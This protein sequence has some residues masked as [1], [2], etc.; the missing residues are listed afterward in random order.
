MKRTLWFF[1]AVSM[2]M[3]V[4]AR[5]APQIQLDF[6]KLA[7][8]AVEKVEVALPK[9][10]LSLAAQFISED[11]KDAAK[12]KKLAGNLNGIY[13]RS[14]EFEKEGEFSLQDLEP[15]RRTITGS[16]WNCLVSVRNKKTS[17]NTDVCLRQDGEKIL[18]LAIL[19]T[20]PKKFTIVNILGSITPEELTTLQGAFG[21]PKDLT[22]KSPKPDKKKDK[23][24]DNDDN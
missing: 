13:V 15:L 20:E 18:G 17:E 19:T 9:S 3:T 6:P 11:D 14:Y 7:E 16:G 23:E 21:I 22:G 12:I 10:L 2:T 24:K 5:Q 4:W 8:K 1:A